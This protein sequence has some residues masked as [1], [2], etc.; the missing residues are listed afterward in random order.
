MGGTQYTR[1]APPDSVINVQDFKSPKHL[2]EYLLELDKD[3]KKYNRYFEWKKKY[4]VLGP[5]ETFKEGF[6]K[7]CETLHNPNFPNKHVFNDLES[8]WG[9]HIYCNINK[10]RHIMGKA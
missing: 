9:K 1:D 2:A 6:C 7:L 4:K 10:W 8:W 3:D 5:K